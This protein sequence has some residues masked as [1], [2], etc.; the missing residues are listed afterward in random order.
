MS[1]L[2]DTPLKDMVDIYRH[3]YNNSPAGI[4]ALGHASSIVILG[5]SM[6]HMKM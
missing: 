4:H 5:M 2:A 6:G 3:G 1:A